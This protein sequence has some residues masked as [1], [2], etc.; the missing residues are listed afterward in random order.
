MLSRSTCLFAQLQDPEVCWRTNYLGF[1]HNTS[2]CWVRNLPSAAIP[3]GTCTHQQISFQTRIQE[4]GK[5][6]G[7]LLQQSGPNQSSALRNIMITFV[8][9]HLLP[10]CLVLWLDFYGLF[11]VE[12][13]KQWSEAY[14]R[15]SALEQGKLESNKKPKTK[16]CILNL[17]IFLT[18]S[19]HVLKNN[20][21][22]VSFLTV[23][24][25]GSSMCCEIKNKTRRLCVQMHT[26]PVWPKQKRCFCQLQLLQF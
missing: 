24:T 13:N 17:I 15:R 25:Q 23:T 2:L 21:S 18:T 19:L 22:F 12:D 20:L 9:L 8:S 11:T 16:I 1:L 4:G 5:I 26:E 6:R 7:E 3:Q 14:K 10:V